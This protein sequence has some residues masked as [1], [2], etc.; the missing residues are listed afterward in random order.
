MTKNTRFIAIFILALNILILWLPNQFQTSGIQ[1]EWRY[2]APFDGGITTYND[3]GSDSSEEQFFTRPMYGLM[4]GLSYVLFPESF[5][6]HHL[7]LITLLL[8]KGIAMFLVFAVL[9][10]HHP[11]WGFFAALLI[12]VYPSD[13]GIVSFRTFHHHLTVASILYSV[14]FFVRYYK[15]HR[16]AH[17]IAMWIAQ[18]IAALSAETG[19]PVFFIVP[20]IILLLEKRLTRRVFQLTVLYY[21]MPAITFAYSVYLILG[22]QTSWQRTALISYTLRDYLKIILNVYTHN[23]I[24]T[25]QSL[26][27]YFV[28]ASTASDKLVFGLTTSATTLGGL[29]IM[30][31]NP[32]Q[33]IANK[34]T[35][36]IKFGVTITLGFVLVL[37]GYGMFLASRTHVLTDFRVYMLSSIGATLVVITLGY[38]LYQASSQA[39]WRALVILTLSS[40]VGLAGVF[41]N[42]THHEFL[43]I[44]NTQQNIV[45]QITEAVPAL[46]QPAYIVIKTPSNEINYR[47]NIDQLQKPVLFTPMLQ[48]LY[49]DYE[50]ILG[51]VICFKE[52]LQCDFTSADGMQIHAS[53]FLNMNTPIPYDQMILFDITKHEELILI[54]EDDNLA[55]YNPMALIDTSAEPPARITSF[56]GTD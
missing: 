44:S 19:Y 29:W 27:T 25:W 55:G 11:L 53:N 9:F 47:V 26:I 30:R 51:G 32:T 17:L 42:K 12:V 50:Q 8:L 1:E 31:R 49:N 6:G 18:L 14:Y 36:L 7:V 37:A 28:S 5:M 3:I 15:S 56:Y 23:F 33:A 21:I 41:A 13:T 45:R 35:L 2:R 20:V 39:I 34:R 4:N 46:S 22:V 38:A 10:P 24:D 52:Y 40:L 43:D 16:R 54:T 48:V